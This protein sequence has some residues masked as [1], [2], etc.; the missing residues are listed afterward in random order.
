VND[1][2]LPVIAQN[3]PIV[4]HCFVQGLVQQRNGT[5]YLYLNSCTVV[6]PAH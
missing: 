5:D 6:P 4:A 1:T 3:Q 2:G